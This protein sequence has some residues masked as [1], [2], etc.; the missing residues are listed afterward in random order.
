[1]VALSEAA[2][3]AEHNGLDLSKLFD[4]LGGGYAGSQLLETKKANLIDRDY[5]PTGV[6]QF[7]VK[8]LRFAEQAAVQTGTVAPQLRLLRTIFED[9][10]DKGLGHEDLAVVHAYIDGLR[11]ESLP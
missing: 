11:D 8:D 7:M 3:I 5:T 6:A 4:T 2:L 10:V 1:M 9:L